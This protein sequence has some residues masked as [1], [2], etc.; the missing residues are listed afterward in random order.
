MAEADLTRLRTFIDDT[1]ERGEQR[2]PPEPRLSEE[3]G[4][5]R[6]QLR[7]LLKKLEDEGAIWRN[8]GKGTAPDDR[9][10]RRLDLLQRGRH[11]SRRSAVMIQRAQKG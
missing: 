8:V 7:T 9:D 4:V 11:L 5:L 6:G 1:L 2:L 3:L 10:A